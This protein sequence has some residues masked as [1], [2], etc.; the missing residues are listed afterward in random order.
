MKMRPLAGVL[1]MILLPIGETS[2]TNYRTRATRRMGEPGLW[3]TIYGSLSSNPCIG[4]AEL[5]YLG[6]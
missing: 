5:R 3:R 4:S 6:R 1:L 2:G